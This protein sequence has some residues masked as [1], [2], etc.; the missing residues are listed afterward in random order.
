LQ[1]KVENTHTNYTGNVVE[2]EEKLTATREIKNDYT[3]FLPS[4]AFKYSPT[5]NIVVR[6]AYSTALARP[7]Y[8]KLSLSL[9]LFQMTETLLL[10]IQI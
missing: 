8:Y 10:G 3:N 1:G 6:A 7:S 9:V 5:T 4:L 2:D